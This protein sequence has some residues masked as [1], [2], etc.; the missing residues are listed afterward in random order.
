MSKRSQTQAQTQKEV[1]TKTYWKVKTIFETFAKYQVQKINI[2]P[3]AFRVIEK[4]LLTMG[5]SV[6]VYE[7]KRDNFNHYLCPCDGGIIGHIS[8][9]EIDISNKV[10]CQKMVCSLCGTIY[11]EKIWKKLLDKTPIHQTG[12]ERKKNM[13][14]MRN[15]LVR[16]FNK[17]PPMHSDDEATKVMAILEKHYFPFHHYLKKDEVVF[18]E[19]LIKICS[20]KQYFNMFELEP[21]IYKYMEAPLMPLCTGYF[22]KC[23]FN[24]AWIMAHRFSNNFSDN[25]CDLYP[26]ITLWNIIQDEKVKTI[27][28]KEF[29]ECCSFLQKWQLETEAYLEKNCLANIPTSNT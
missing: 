25:I 20:G 17:I 9:I 12:E 27:K 11:P 29:G 2:R 21:H 22:V 28:Y 13:K 19:N 23:F 1:E 7:Q 5:Y 14:H 15:K 16:L 8:S 24:P 6:T 4:H 10:Y 3:Q 26:L 18:I